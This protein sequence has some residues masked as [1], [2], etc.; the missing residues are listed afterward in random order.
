MPKL[1]HYILNEIIAKI[2]DELSISMTE[3][4]ILE[5]RLTKLVNEQQILKN[6]LDD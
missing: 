5:G 6:N 2:T 1:L 3:R 4:N